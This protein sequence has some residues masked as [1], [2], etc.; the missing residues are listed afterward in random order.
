MAV[1]FGG[2]VVRESYLRLVADRLPA[3]RG[4][5]FFAAGDACFDVTFADVPFV[6]ARV[7]G[8]GLDAGAALDCL[9]NR[10][11]GAPN[12]RLKA[13]L[14]AGS[15]SY[16]TAAATWATLWLVEASMRAPSCSRHEVR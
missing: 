10:A 16:P 1:G 15:D 2:G 3:R 13:R 11:G 7:P 14:N 4:D 5:R 8:A 12:C 9:R 6:A